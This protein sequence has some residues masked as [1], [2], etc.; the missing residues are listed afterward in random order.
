VNFNVNKEAD[1][2]RGL[3]TPIPIHPGLLADVS[4]DTVWNT[5]IVSHNNNKHTNSARKIPRGFANL[6]KISRRKNNSSRFPGVLD[7]LCESS[8]GLAHY[9]M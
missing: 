8:S 1:V 4:T 3:L 9:V 7:T 5:R 6:Q 2:Y